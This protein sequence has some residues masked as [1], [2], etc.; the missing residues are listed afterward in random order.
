[1]TQIAQ[2]IAVDEFGIDRR[3]IG[4]AKTLMHEINLCNRSNLRLRSLRFGD[5]LVLYRKIHRICN[6]A[7]FVSTLMQRLGLAS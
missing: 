7:K 5:R 4:I 2:M 3:K 6:E 1:M